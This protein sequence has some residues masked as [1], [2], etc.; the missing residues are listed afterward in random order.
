M[1]ATSTRPSILRTTSMA[2]MVSAGLL[3]GTP[4]ATITATDALAAGS[5]SEPAK[6]AE[7]CKRGE[8]YSKRQKKCV[9]EESSSVTNEDRYETGRA[10]AH[11]GRFEDAIELLRTA[12]ASDPRVLNYLGYAS[13]NAGRVEEGMAYYE[14]ALAIDPNFTLARSYMGQALLLQGDEAGAWE[15]LELIA[16]VSGIEGPDYVQLRDALRDSGTTGA[17]FYRR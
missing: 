15:Q 9:P 3:L 10:L 8:V 11:A 1:N 14:R 2:V 13:R 6:S 16:R 4:L 7:K 17:D 12:D 5:S